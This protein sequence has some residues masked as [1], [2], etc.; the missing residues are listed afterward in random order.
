MASVKWSVVV[1]TNR[2]EQFTEFVKAW[3]P[4]FTKHNVHLVVVQDLPEHDEQIVDSLQNVKFTFRLLNQSHLTTKHIPIQTDMIRSYGFYYVWKERLSEYILTLD[5]DVRPV[6]DI[7]DEYE[8]VFDAGAPVSEYLDVGALTSSKLNMRGFPYKDRQKQTVGV[9]YGGWHGVL[10]YD[11]ATQLAHPEPQQLFRPINLVVPKNTPVTC[12]IMNC[13]FR[14]ELTPIM[15]QLP[16]YKGRY[17]RVGDIWSGLFI[18]K[19]LDN[20]NVAMTI[21][22]K[23][24]VIHE[25]ASNPY[26]SL[27]KEAPGV[28]LNDYLWENLGGKNYREITDSAI[29]FFAKHDV[30]YADKFKKARDE[31]LDLFAPTETT[32]P[33][34]P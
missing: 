7:F 13:A 18:K 31:W 5:D 12:C 16:M 22:G 23:A 6:N 24:S 1:P 15:W 29:D 26:A 11:A 10:D 34:K 9:Q 20:I 32:K 17:N 19:T 2:P 28:L 21:S 3:T 33:T 8:Q 14:T 27:E 30:H 4:L 25:R